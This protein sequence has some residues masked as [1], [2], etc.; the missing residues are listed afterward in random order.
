MMARFSSWFFLVMLNFRRQLMS[1]KMLIVIFLLLLSWTVVWAAASHGRLEDPRRFTNVVVIRLLAGFLFPLMMICFGTATITDERY[2]GTMVYLRSRPL[3]RRGIY[4]G[5]LVAILPTAVIAVLGG[6]F[7]M[8][9]I[10]DRYSDGIFDQ[11]TAF[12]PAFFLGTLAYVALF[13]L[14]S[15]VFKHA[16]LIALAYLFIV[17]MF[18]AN[19]PG[20]LKRATVNFYV[21]SMIF[22]A[23]A[24]TVQL[25]PKHIAAFQPVDGDSAMMTLLGLTIGFIVAGAVY[26]GRAEYRDEN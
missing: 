16:T 6:Y 4:V 14:L 10:A 1:R 26:F 21:S 12:V 18:I 2:E 3:S 22:E 23:S 9:V 25:R 13:H 8:C 20:M 11:F 19:T 17:E 5:K 15:A 24:T 7:G